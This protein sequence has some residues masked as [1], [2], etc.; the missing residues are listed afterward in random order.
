MIIA[1]ALGGAACFAAIVL[2]CASAAGREEW[3]DVDILDAELLRSFD[4]HQHASEVQP[5]WLRGVSVGA[6]INNIDHSTLV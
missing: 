1:T 5:D 2:V 4:Q 3:S 6:E